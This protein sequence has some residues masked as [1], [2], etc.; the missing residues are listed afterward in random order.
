[1]KN[2]GSS[3]KNGDNRSVIEKVVMNGSLAKLTPAE[4]YEYYE[5][6][7]ESVGLNP[8]TRPFSYLELDGKLVLYA[9]TDATDQLRKLHNISITIVNREQIGD[10]YCVTARAET[11]DGR[12]DESIGAVPLLKEEKV[13]DAGERRKVKTGN[14]LPLTSEEMANAIMKAETKAKRRVT[15]SLIG[16]GMMDEGFEAGS[17]MEAMIEG[18]QQAD[19]SNK[20]ASKPEAPVA[21]SAEE[22]PKEEVYELLD[23]STGTSPLKVTF[24]KLLVKNLS[25]GREEY[26]FA[27]TPESLEQATALSNHSHFRAELEYVDNIAT[28][29]SITIVSVGDAA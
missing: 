18:P 14:I 4:R 21:S 6:V 25:S 23:F 11:G 28:I 26:L 2:T 24:G 10:V 7:C 19:R 8:V 22:S 12:S 3:G 17:G 16:L 15:L 1:M 9:N 27:K 20:N 13:W 5:Q 29:L